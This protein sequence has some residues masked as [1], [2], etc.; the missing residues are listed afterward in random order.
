MPREARPH[1]FSKNGLV[2]GTVLLDGFVGAVWRA[3]KG[4]V[5]VTPLRG[6]TGAERSEVEAEGTR[7]AEFLGGP[8]GELPVGPVAA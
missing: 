5:T 1:L 7:L 3:E 6:L 2:P 8:G 4:I